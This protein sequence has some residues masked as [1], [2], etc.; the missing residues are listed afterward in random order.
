MTRLLLAAPVYL[1]L[2]T[3][4][5]A[6]APAPPL[7]A[8]LARP[9]PRTVILKSQTLEIGQAPSV[10][11]TVAHYLTFGAVQAATGLKARQPFNVM[12]DHDGVDTDTYTLTVN[13]VVT[14]TLTIG[15]LVNGVITFPFLQ[16]LPKGSYT[17][18]VTAIGPGGTGIGDALGQIIAPG[19]P[20]K[21][22]KTRITIIG[23]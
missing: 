6:Q 8:E 17:V 12:A 7:T 22:T 11:R 15:A 21:P 19:P 4:A 1:V 23:G 14:Q 3:A 5:L 10:W 18:I 16:G 9:G 20:S 13:G 2:A